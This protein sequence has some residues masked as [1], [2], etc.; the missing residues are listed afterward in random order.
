MNVQRLLGL[1]ELAARRTWEGW[2]AVY[3]MVFQ[4]EVLSVKAFPAHV[5]LE[6]LFP[7]EVSVP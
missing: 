3:C 2:L 6:P 5:T 1:E 4:E 7:M